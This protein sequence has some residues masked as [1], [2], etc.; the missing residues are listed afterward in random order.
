MTRMSVFALTAI[1][2]LGSL[3]F[4]TDAFAAHAGGGGHGGGGHH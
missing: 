2:A 4:A 1:L 3:S